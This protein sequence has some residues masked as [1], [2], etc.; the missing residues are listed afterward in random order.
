MKNYDHR[1][2]PDKTTAIRI[3]NTIRQAREARGLSIQTA[4]Y[5][6]KVRSYIFAK[7]EQGANYA[8]L[9]TVKRIC[10]YLGVILDDK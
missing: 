2:F 7:I 4:A 1:T 5:K 8:Q 10:E 9:T 6:C 3:G